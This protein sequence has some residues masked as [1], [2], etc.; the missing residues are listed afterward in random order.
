MN[1]RPSFVRLD[2]LEFFRWV[3][4]HKEDLSSAVSNLAKCL[5]LGK[6]EE[7]SYARKL[8]D[9]ANEFRSKKSEAGRK[10]MESRWG[11][12]Q[13][14]ANGNAA[15]DRN[16]LTSCNKSPP[17]PKKASAPVARSAAGRGPRTKL[18]F[19]TFIYEP[20]N[21]INTALAWEWYDIHKARDW[22]DKAGVPLTNWKGALINYCKAK[23]ADN[24]LQ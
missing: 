19:E 5:M 9:E 23:E 17:N 11:N 3:D 14:A 8:L 12:S 2:V 4:D 24:E 6:A 15:E 18:E 20:S 22:T 16:P 10:G 21:N 13:E 1:T 7:G